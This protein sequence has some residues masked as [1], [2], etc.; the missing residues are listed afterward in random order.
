MQEAKNERCTL[1]LGETGTVALAMPKK[2]IW[3]CGTFQGR[4]LGTAGIR[5]KRR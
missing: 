2:N 4:R 1:L 3:N 5:I